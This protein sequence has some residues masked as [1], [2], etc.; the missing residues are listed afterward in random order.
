[1][2]KVLYMVLPCFNEGEVLPETSKQLKEKVEDLI[3]KNK[4]SKKDIAC[5]YHVSYD[6]VKN[7]FDF[8]EFYLH[9]LIHN[10]DTSKFNFDIVKE[11]VESPNFPFMG[12]KDIAYQIFEL[13]FGQNSFVRLSPQKIANQLKIYYSEEWI[14][15]TLT[16]FMLSVKK[17]E[18][19]KNSDTQEYVSF[20]M[21]SIEDVI[22]FLR[23]KKARKLPLSLR[24]AI[25]S[26]YS[27]SGRHVMFPNDKKKVFELLDSLE[28]MRRNENGFYRVLK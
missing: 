12:D 27:L 25:L 7:T 16:S 19:Q 11:V 3:A 18:F 10:H 4:I 6:S 1:M 26:F 24:E 23:S 14:M 15:D 22:S 8:L 2:S 9:E 20:S 21:M 13:Y 28:V 5:K 17:Y